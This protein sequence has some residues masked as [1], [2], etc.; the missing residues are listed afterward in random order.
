MS[1]REAPHPVELAARVRA[2]RNAA[3]RCNRQSLDR[4]ARSIATV[5]E[6][7]L[8]SNSPWMTRAVDELTTHTRFTRAMLSYA[9][10]RMIEPLRGDAIEQLVRSELGTWPPVNV[11]SIGLVLHVLPSNLPAHAAISSA[12][13]LVLGGA[14][15]LKAGRDDRVFG[16]LWIESLREVDNDLG[17]SVDCAYWRGGDSSCEDRLLEEADLVIAHGGDRAIE[18]LAERCRNR[19][20]GHGH[21]LSIALLAAGIDYVDVSRRLADDVVVWD[22]LGCLSPQ[23][24]FVEGGIRQAV[25]FAKA[26][27]A[28]MKILATKVP[29][30]P[31]TQ[32][33]A[34]TI[35]NFR[36]TAEWSGLATGAQRLFAPSSELACGSV[37]VED[38]LS[39]APTPLHRCVRVVPFT[40][41][42]EVCKL[43]EGHRMILEGAALEAATPQRERELQAMLEQ[44]GVPHVV[45]AGEL[46]KPT[47]EWRQG[48]RGRIVGTYWENTF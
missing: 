42:T 5:A 18:S 21:R 6:N 43:I 10:P 1:V 37:A 44:S 17:A 15:F 47:L 28:E 20:V 32:G 7:W 4:R 41:I 11:P 46:Q 34:L 29:A 2:I 19:F 48:G 31:L 39:F 45:A 25:G 24:C 26:L 33:E 3:G 40:S 16:Q 8:R 14:C 38:N 13:T 36:D 30:G 22:Q 12:L 23:V 35:R 9:L 27:A